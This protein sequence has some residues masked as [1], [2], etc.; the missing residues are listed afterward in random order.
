[1]STYMINTPLGFA[2]VEATDAIEAFINYV[3]EHQPLEDL[4]LDRE[5]LERK[6]WKTAQA[7]TIANVFKLSKEV[8]S[9]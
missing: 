9:V 6:G 5:D 2:L 1:M 7:T 3:T 4:F 8:A